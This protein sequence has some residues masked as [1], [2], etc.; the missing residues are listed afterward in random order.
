MNS[1]TVV[2][3]EHGHIGK[4]TT[5]RRRPRSILSLLIDENAV[6]LNAKKVFTLSGFEAHAGSTYRRSAASIVLEDGRSL[7]ECKTQMLHKCMTPKLK[8]HER[9]RSC[10]PQYQSDDKCSICYSE[11]CLGL[12]D[13]PEGKWFCPSCR[14]GLCGQSSAL[15]GNVGEFIAAMVLH[16]DQCRRDYHIG[17]FK[18]RGLAIKLE[19]KGGDPEVSSVADQ[20]RTECHRKLNVAL[21]IMHEYFDPINEPLT[22]SDLIEDLIFS[23]WSELNWLN[24]LGFFTVLLQQGGELISVATVRIHDEKVAEVPFIA[25]HSQYRQKGMCHLLMNELEKKLIE[26]GVERLV[27]PATDERLNMWTTYF[28][29]SK[30]TNS[31]RLKYIEYNIVLFEDTVMC[32]KLLRKMSST[33]QGYECIDFEMAQEDQIELSEVKQL[34][35]Y[36]CSNKPIEPTLFRVLICIGKPVSSNHL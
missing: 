22:N 11:G 32:Q 7:L 8:T 24:Y 3:P 16:C 33:N 35:S 29:F 31:E 23:K 14:C 27:L 25:T 21:R 12:R 20:V 15:S 13:L 5:P 6:L 34:Q 10:L 30:M 36:N 18:E 19:G 1:S 17:C 9:I 4:L 28:G 26:L 2:V